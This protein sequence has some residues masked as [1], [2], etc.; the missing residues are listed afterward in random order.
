[1]RPA[2]KHQGG[3]SLRSRV[4]VVDHLLRAAAAI[5][6]ESTFH[7]HGSA[8][9]LVTRRHDVDVPDVVQRSWRRI[10]FRPANH[11]DRSIDRRRA[12]SGLR[13]RQYIWRLSCGRCPLEQ[14]HEI[15]HA[16]RVVS[17]L[18]RGVN[19]F[20]RGRFHGRRAPAFSGHRLVSARDRPWRPL[21]RRRSRRYRTTSRRPVPGQPLPSAVAGGQAV[22]TTIKSTKSGPRPPPLYRCS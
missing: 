20:C 18:L 22:R 8:A 12:G 5:T 17:A 21:W 6:V 11:R 19:Y 16:H 14:G 7:V 10:S 15:S 3:A 13:V 4:P 1:M 2:D 9:I